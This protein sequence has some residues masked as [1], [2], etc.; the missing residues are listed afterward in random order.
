MN[1]VQLR[2]KIVTQIDRLSP[3]R[4]ALVSEFLDSL[5]SLESIDSSPVR[6]LPPIKR[7]NTA[8]DL[9]KFAATWQ[10]DDLEECLNF[11]YESRSKTQF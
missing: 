4:L 11:V 7:G 10:G 1:P 8:Q 5:Q 9:L 6:K 3:E 2:Q